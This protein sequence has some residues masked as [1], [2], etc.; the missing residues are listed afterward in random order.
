MLSSS[1]A[2]YLLER[3][4]IGVQDD[5]VP[6][7]TAAATAL[8]DTARRIE[9]QLTALL[10]D[11]DRVSEEIATIRLRLRD[12][13][14]DPDKLYFVGQDNQPYIIGEMSNG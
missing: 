4:A 2:E 11:D 12:H 6:P 13:G 9:R 5:D 7:K 8:A 10:A 3:F 1:T 14:L